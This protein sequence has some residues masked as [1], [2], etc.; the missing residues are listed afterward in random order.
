M[1]KSTVAITVQ[2]YLD[3]CDFEAEHFM[4]DD[5]AREGVEEVMHDDCEVEKAIEFLSARGFGVHTDEVWM[6]I[7]ISEYKDFRFE[8][9]SYEWEEEAHKYV[10]TV[11]EK[12]ESGDEEYLAF[13]E[14]VTPDDKTTIEY[15]LVKYGMYKQLKGECH[16]T[17][18][19]VFDDL[20]TD[21]S[22]PEVYEDYKAVMSTYPQTTKHPPLPQG[23][24]I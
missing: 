13:F 5:E 20:V 18:A 21:F 17:D 12:L 2:S 19:D 7:A 11:V 22:K 6:R 23:V 14:G 15:V 10:D 3:G 4:S 8:D 24:R 1:D 9:L 16:W